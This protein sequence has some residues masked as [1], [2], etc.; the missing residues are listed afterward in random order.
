MSNKSAATTDVAQYIIL[1]DKLIKEQSELIELL[2]EADGIR[3][4]EN[5][6]ALWKHYEKK[7]DDLEKLYAL[8]LKFRG[9]E[10][11]NKKKEMIEKAN[12]KLQNYHVIKDDSILQTIRDDKEFISE[13]QN[14]MSE[15]GIREIAVDQ[16]QNER[17]PNVADLRNKVENF[18]YDNPAKIVSALKKVADQTSIIEEKFEKLRTSYESYISK[19]NNMKSQEQG[20]SDYTEQKVLIS[21]NYVLKEIDKSVNHEQIESHKLFEM[22]EE[23]CKLS[24]QRYE[25]NNEYPLL[26]EEIKSRLNKMGLDENGKL[27]DNKEDIYQNPVETKVRYVGSNSLNNRKR[28]SF[29]ELSN[30]ELTGKLAK[31][32]ERDKEVDEEFYC[33]IKELSQNVIKDN[34]NQKG[35]ESRETLKKE[36]LAKILSDKHKIGRISP[37][38]KLDQDFWQQTRGLEG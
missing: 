36:I 8:D 21:T 27:A 13:L 37:D 38:N 20:N 32:M 2:K 35:R 15:I 14:V 30:R 12:E 19:L 25:I 26:L 5:I 9:D 10:L 3:L 6:Q 18:D 7:C 34:Q 17:E 29:K 11:S 24:A 1:T 16:M 4:K 22:Y 23:A 28:K 31:V 33:L